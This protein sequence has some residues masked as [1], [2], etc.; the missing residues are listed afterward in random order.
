MTEKAGARGTVAVIYEFFDKATEFTG[1]H[2]G[3]VTQFYSDALMATFNL[4]L[5]DPH[6]AAHAVHA[7]ENIL[8][9]VENTKFGGHDLSVR[10]GVRP[11]TSWPAMSM[12]AAGKATRSMATP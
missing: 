4:S 12:V 7:A 2:H 10:I 5:E 1:Q 6:H 9:A 8:S 11:A 3:T